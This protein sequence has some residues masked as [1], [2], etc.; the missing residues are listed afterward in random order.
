MWSD[1]VAATTWGLVWLFGVG[2]SYYWVER[3]VV[4]VGQVTLPL[5]M[6][7]VPVWG[8]L[9][10]VAGVVRLLPVFLLPV[11]A[12]YDIE[13]F[14]LVGDALVHNEEVYTSAARGRH[15][16]LP[17]Q[18][19][20]IGLL[21]RLSQLLPLPFVVLIKIPGVL[22]DLGI[23][24]LIYRT[25]RARGWSDAR[26]MAWG[27][28]YALNPVAILVSAYHGQF[29]AL[30]VFLLLLAWYVWSVYG[31]EMRS[32]VVLG[33]AIL[34]KTWPI[35][36]LPIMLLRLR[37][38]RRRLIYG[39]LAVM[40]P[41]LATVFYIWLFQS[42]PR[43]MLRRA[44]THSGVP[45]YY[46]YSA[47]LAVFF[48]DAPWYEGVFDGL[49]AN[50][51]WVLVGVGLL[52]VWL[53]RRESV[54]DALTTVLV[55]IFVLTAGMGIQWFVWLVPVAL[56]AGDVRWL[57]RY[58]WGGVCFLVVQLYGLHMYPWLYEWFSRETADS[59]FRLGS[60]PA[61]LVVVAWAGVRWRRL[62]TG[63]RVRD[64]LWRV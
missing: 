15:P 34:S 33:L 1:V 24:W 11:G 47:L 59:L 28:L 5:W 62:L 49:V 41:V 25:G 55:T 64:L 32:A 36:L 58:T 37:G 6:R 63:V 21:F 30:P 14:R 9:L 38:V 10:L 57:G 18:V 31:H 48:G 3:K 43:P 56:L 50:V 54:L 53:T 52:S 12:G 42:N 61:W 20:V 51:R 29:D 13:S 19:Y 23:V 60:L 16:Y 8:W 4:G 44:L 39:G 2:A 22:A 35:A 17:F 46:G 40:V 27:L 7:R 26:T 45:G